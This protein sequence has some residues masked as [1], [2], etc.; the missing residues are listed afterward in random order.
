MASL[1]KKLW[2]RLKYLHDLALARNLN[3]FVCDLLVFETFLSTLINENPGRTFR[4]NQTRWDG[5]ISYANEIVAQ[6]NQS[7]SLVSFGV[8]VKFSHSVAKLAQLK[9]LLKYVCLAMF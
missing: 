3:E 2:N 5:V 6:I 1:G 7:S 4:V 9:Q 8:F